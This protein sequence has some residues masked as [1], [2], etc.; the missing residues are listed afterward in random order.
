MATW[1][2]K[3]VMVLRSEVPRP[4][5]P[6]NS[7]GNAACWAPHQTCWMSVLGWGAAFCVNMPSRCVMLTHI[8]ELK[9]EAF[10]GG[11]WAKLPCPPFVLQVL[12]LFLSQVCPVQLS[13]LPFLIPSLPYA[14][15]TQ[16]QRHMHLF[17]YSSSLA[18]LQCVFSFFPFTIHLLS[19]C[20]RSIFSVSEAALSWGYRGKQKR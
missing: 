18:A 10:T 11:F 5:S 3:E 1:E 16:G 15:P 2:K 4:A 13:P 7:I 8:R 14:V 9:T 6:G 17:V 12:A 19:D 20:L